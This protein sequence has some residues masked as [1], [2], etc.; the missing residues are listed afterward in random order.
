MVKAFPETTPSNTD[1][2]SRI[3]LGVGI[4]Q[5]DTNSEGCQR[6]SQVDR[7]GSLTYTAL[8][9]GNCDYLRHTER[10][11]SSRLNRAK[12]TTQQWTSATVEGIE[13]V[14]STVAEAWFNV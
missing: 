1:A 14:L 8:L 11:V 5:Q 4:Y 12:T 7:R 13:R 10:I 6:R 9:I 3:P 2:R